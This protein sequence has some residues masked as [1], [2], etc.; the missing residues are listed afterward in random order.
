MT[1]EQLDELGP[2]LDDFLGPYLFCRP[3]A[4]EREGFQQRRSGLTKRA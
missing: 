4:L 2:A 1:E 3:F